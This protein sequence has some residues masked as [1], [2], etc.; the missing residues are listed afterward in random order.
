MKTLHNLDALKI[1]GGTN[2]SS[3]DTGLLVANVDV[4]AHNDYQIIGVVAVVSG[5]PMFDQIKGILPE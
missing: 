5:H 4:P 2:K 1:H 3:T